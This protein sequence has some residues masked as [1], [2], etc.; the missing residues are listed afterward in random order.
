MPAEGKVCNTLEGLFDMLANKFKPQYNKTIKSLQ[1]RKLCW[2]ESE[3]LE[4]CM[5]RL[6]VVA[7][8]CNYR[9][10]ARQL[11]E[12]FIQGLND[13]CTLDEIIKELTTTKDDH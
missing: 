12:Q 8:E 10:V 7:V 9:E 4:E 3:N 6:H 1:F 5:G 11:K 13:K 2:L